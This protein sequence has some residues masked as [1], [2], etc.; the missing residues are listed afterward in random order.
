MA[1]I[2][3]TLAAQVPTFDP[4]T[5]LA[6]AAKIQA[7][8][9]E[10]QQAQFKQNQLELGSEMRGVQP[11][12]NTPEFPTKWREAADR[13][14]AKGVI[15]DQMYN[16]WANS[17]SPLLLKSIIN[18]TDSPELAFRKEDAQRTQ[19]NA[20][21]N[22]ALQKRAQDRLDRTS[23][24]TESDTV[25]ERIDA[26]KRAGIDPNTPEGKTYI[27]T[28]GLPAASAT[29]IADQSNQRKKIA[30]ENGLDPSSPGYQSYVLTGK[31]PRE[32]S[33]PLTSTDKKA[34]FDSEDDN[35]T[36][37]TQ[38]ETLKRA[39]ELNDKTFTGFGAGARGW[40]GT[41][42]PGAGYVMDADA[43]KA[44]REFGQ[45]M[46]GEAISS[47]SKTLKGATTDTEMKRFI[48]MLSDP[49]T[50]PE[51][52][53]RIIDRLSG[54]AQRQFDINKSRI[55]DLRGGSYYKP[56]NKPDADTLRKQAKEAID[57]GAP[58]EEVIKRLKQQG[59][60]ADGL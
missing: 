22:F 56:K 4:A 2:D 7:A 5:P 23:N 13:L 39:K 29:S 60:N 49:T 47:M 11:F 54:Q 38:I 8:N 12:V 51:I 57:A 10:I 58:R 53:T 42:L 45:L 9:Q 31:M 44:T 6:Q 55:D 48:E 30:A 43:A 50:P 20:D 19:A 17:P 26:A 16:Q 14:R 41:A 46:Q 40:A 27:L 24:K 21:R 18:Q 59:V 32:D 52:R 15:N 25:L 28:G 36:L 33:Q 3:N 34:I 37:Q 35:V 1:I